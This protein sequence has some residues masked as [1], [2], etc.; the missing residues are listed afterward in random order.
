MQVPE[1]L[2]EP[3]RWER[4]M[5][6]TASTMWRRSGRDHPG[7]IRIET[8]PSSRGPAPRKRRAEPSMPFLDAIGFVRRGVLYRFNGGDPAISD[9]ESLQSA[10]DPVEPFR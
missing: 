7:Q 2:G 10:L 5:L 1:E 3:F 9:D 8:G 4:R 6:R